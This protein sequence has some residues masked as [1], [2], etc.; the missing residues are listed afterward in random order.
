MKSETLILLRHPRFVASAIVLSCLLERELAGAEGCPAPSFAVPLSF[1]SG[2]NPVSVAVGDFNADD[3][4]D[5]AVADDGYIL[6]TGSQE[7]GALWVLLGKG[8]GTFQA[9]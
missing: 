2:T 7:N 3:K 5:L 6:A 9:A 4:P 1:Q 8:D